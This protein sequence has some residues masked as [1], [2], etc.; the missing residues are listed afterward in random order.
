MSEHTHPLPLADAQQAGVH[1]VNTE[2]ARRVFHAAAELHLDVHRIELGNTESA[3]ALFERFA[4]ALR[5]PEWFGHNWDALADCLC[6]LS[7]FNAE[8]YVLILSG[9]PQLAHQHAAMTETLL[10]VLED[11]SSAWREINQ[12]FWVLICDDA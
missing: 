5:F 7:W 8:G 12:P 2:L 6:D 10:T 1:R 11:A 9:I 3:E 4:H